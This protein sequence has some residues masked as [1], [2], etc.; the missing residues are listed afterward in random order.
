MADIDPFAALPDI[1]PAEVDPFA[2]LPDIA[3]ATVASNRSVGEELARGLV[4]AP[5]EMAQ[6][7]SELATAGFDLAFGTSATRPTTEFFDNIKSYT[8]PDTTT[9]EVAGAL[10]S[11]IIAFLPVAGWIG[12]AGTAAKAANLGKVLVPSTSVFLRSAE[13]FGA[14]PAG[15]ALLK[16]KGGLFG[17]TAVLSGAVDTVLAPDGRVTLSD[18]FGTGGPLMTEDDTGLGGRE[19][20]LRILRNKLRVGAEGAAASLAFDVGLA[21][22]A[23]GVSAVGGTNA[24]ANLA[25]GVLTGF[26]VLGSAVS[27]VP[28]AKAVG[29]FADKYLSATGGADPKIFEQGMDTVARIDATEAGGIKAYRDF[30]KS[31]TN[32]L[33]VM[34]LW[35]KGRQVAKSAERDLTSFLTGVGPRLDKYGPKV[36][37]AADRL[38][39]T[40]NAI[41]KNFI[42]TLE[43]ELK[44]ALPETDR[45]LKI[46]AAIDLMKDHQ[47]AELGFLRR[48][49][50]VHTDP[51]AYY[52]S[53]KLAGK[54]K[55]AYDAAVDEVARHTL[56]G[57]PLTEDALAA[58]RHTVNKSM[59]LEAINLGAS[60]Q[61]AI[62]QVIQSIK[63]NQ[64]RPVGPV[65][66]TSPRFKMTP[67]LLTPREDIVN[68]SPKLRSLLGEI[69]DPKQMYL[70]TIGDMVKTTE[71]LKFYRRI[72]ESGMVSSLA[73][74]I[75]NINKGIRPTF[76]K[77]PN[78][79]PNSRIVDLDFDQQP[80][81]AEA[82]RLNK[83]EATG[84]EADKRRAEGI[85]PEFGGRNTQDT[86]IQSYTDDLVA[87]GYIKLGE[88]D[89]IGDVFVG[90][91][92]SLSGIYVAPES[93]QA[94]TAPLMSGSTFLNEFRSVLAQIKGFSQRM[95]LVPNPESHIRQILSNTMSLFAGDNLGRSTEVFDVLKVFTNSLARLDDQG[96]DKLA[97]QLAESGVL[98]ENLIVKAL[99]EFRS[100][101]ESLTVGGKTR[102][103][104]D[105]IQKVLLL[106][107]GP[108]LEALY[109][110][111]DA[112]FKGIGVVSEQSKLMNA[113]A[114]AGLDA[115]TGGPMVKAL[116]QELESSGL[117]KRLA[118]SASPDLSA[119]AVIAADIIKDIMPNYGRVG[120]LFRELQALP[121]FGN[122][123]SFASETIRNSVNMLDRGLKE[124]AF[125]VSPGVR[126]SIG[127]EAARAFER[128][129]R[130]QGARRLTSYATI[131]AVLPKSAV[132]FGMAE[133]GT[134]QEQMDAAYSRLPPYTAGQ[135][136][137]PLSNDQK[138]KMTYISLNS[139]MPYAF[140]V[141]PAMAAVRAYNEAGRLDKGTASQIANGVWASVS[142]YL[143]PIVSQG[144]G[145][146]QLADVLPT[147]MYGRGGETTTGSKIYRPSDSLYDRVQ[148]S[149]AHVGLTVFT[150]GYLKEFIEVRSGEIRPGRIRRAITGMSGPQGESFN[151]PVE[152]ARLM[153]GI[154][155]ME[156]NLRRDF[157]F[158]GKEYAPLRGDAKTAASAIIRA[159]DRTAGEMLD[160]WD[161]YLSNLKRVQTKLYGDIQAA[162]TLGLS[163]KDIYR[164]LVDEAKLGKD[165]VSSIMRGKFDPG[166]ATSELMKEIRMQERYDKINRTTPA[167][168]IPIRELNK[169]S[170]DLRGDPLILE[171]PAAAPTRKAIP[172]APAP[173]IDVDPFS[174]LPDLPTEVDPFSTLPDLPAPAPQ[175]QGSIAPMAP[176]APVQRAGLSP[177]LLGGDLASQAANMEIAQRL[178]STG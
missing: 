7:L 20:A 155:P 17:S 166:L 50:K 174:A 46:Q 1:A 25:K 144:I 141:D 164:Q 157:Q 56:A 35:G 122:F 145:I 127:E 113:F 102:D 87:K 60:P 146:E 159:P 64:L 89:N 120:L 21:G 57:A 15:R 160:A 139:V 70:Q 106:G 75:P 84:K 173:S 97:R 158:A 11:G 107:Q 109:A 162:R 61:Q 151:V 95:I 59:G 69:R 86:V 51:L 88:A 62:E 34:R 94:V 2:A 96:L 101:A 143:D 171:G 137:V 40:S 63:T 45:F 125:T 79:D 105:K 78:R 4:T 91:Y 23:K 82:T 85:P 74:A 126:A 31:L 100:S 44:T 167:S 154:T 123:T 13:Q 118:S 148:K 132:Q 81:Y 153:I 136:I 124:M 110:N 90:K 108:K 152:V 33:G 14:S 68:V 142:A 119:L 93:F 3:P 48:S 172:Q 147:D 175:Q 130:G 135:D 47:Q 165:E 49:F 99:K 53:L 133:T 131:A 163:E 116:L 36:A 77:V 52:K 98:D 121:L 43:A 73:D 138:G 161:T 27:K 42:E 128:S 6:G 38:L 72:S 169:M 140:V 176:Q 22:I 26:D 29:N 16:T 178:G 41:R 12:R 156:L 28:G 65:A 111:S 58:A 5:V 30:Q 18:T 168:D 66:T 10:T 134:S 55:A 76:V 24:A 112:I 71:A 170:R 32:T 150:P 37:A 9:G 117:A 67:T 103:V 104:L 54:D 114:A 149:I 83:L 177:S 80:F 8:K 115:D 129:I 39:D 92:G 19:E